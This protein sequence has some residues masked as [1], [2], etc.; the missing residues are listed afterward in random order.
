[1][2]IE[3]GRVVEI[4]YTLRDEAGA[5]VDSSEGGETWTYLHGSGEMIPGLEKA[6]EGRASGDAFKV[7]VP[8]AEGFGERIKGPSL[9]VPRKDL[10]DDHPPE[11]GMQLMGADARGQRQV[12]FITEVHDDHVV[13][14]I[15]HPL[16]GQALDF[17]VTVRSVRDA[18]E[19]EKSHGHAHGADGHHHH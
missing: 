7:K 13:L 3:K 10:P 17:D 12:F 16:A 5:V 9:R 2:K 6:L 18:T 15:N 14:D 11:V 19:E 8:A 4:D 1:M